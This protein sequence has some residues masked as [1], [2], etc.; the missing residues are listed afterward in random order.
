MQAFIDA[1]VPKI[2]EA[3]EWVEARGLATDIQVDGGITPSNVRTVLDAGATVVVAA[4]PAPAGLGV[5]IEDR[6]RKAAAAHE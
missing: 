6:L 1:V 3:R 4:L 5:A 2:A